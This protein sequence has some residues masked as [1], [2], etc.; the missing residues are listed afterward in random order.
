MFAHSSGSL[1]LLPASPKIFHGRDSELKDLIDSL[2]SDPAR[3]AILG[4]GGMGKTTLAIAA[5]HHPE[6]MEKYNLRHF[7]S[8]ESANTCGNLVT[9]IGLHLGLEPS[10]RLS[11]AIVHHFGQC[12]PC[13]VVFDNF[14]TPWES[15]E[16]RAQVEEFLS[17]L[18]DIPSLALL[19]SRP[20]IWFRPNPNRCIAHNERS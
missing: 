11:N 20:V 5:L 1:S 15:F 9:N 3:V 13:L 19:V 17:L 14:E 10:F 12:G 8:C 4:P 16:P 18:A 7:I 6:I 2:L